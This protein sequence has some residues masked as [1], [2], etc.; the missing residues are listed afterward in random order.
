MIS[1]SPALLQLRNRYAVRYFPSQTYFTFPFFLLPFSLFPEGCRY[2]V[3]LSS[4]I[5]QARLPKVPQSHS[6]KVGYAVR[7]PGHGDG[8]NNEILMINDQL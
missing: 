4:G 5:C 3:L 7:G 8:L 6:L 2:A 1:Q